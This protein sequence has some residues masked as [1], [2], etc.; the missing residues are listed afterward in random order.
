M[1]TIETIQY[2]ILVPER[3][4]SMFDE[5]LFIELTA[6]AGFEWPDGSAL[7]IATTEGNYTAIFY[8]NVARVYFDNLFFDDFNS[9]SKSISIFEIFNYSFSLIPK[10]SIGDI[11]ITGYP[12]LPL[13]TKNN[14]LSFPYEIALFLKDGNGN[15]D[16]R[17]LPAITKNYIS[18]VT[19]YRLRNMTGY[20]TQF[21][22]EYATSSVYFTAPREVKKEHV[23]FEWVDDDGNWRSWY[24]MLKETKTESAKA[25][26]DVVKT[27]SARNN[28]RMVSVDIKRNTVSEVYFSGYEQ[29]DVL[30]VLNSI[31]SSSY[32]F[33]GDNKE[34]VNVVSETTTNIDIAKEF[35]FTVK[36]VTK[37]AR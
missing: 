16:P 24:F 31:K 36:S 13:W 21:S 18:D 17:I 19:G 22:D 12:L 28:E 11:K 35:Y 7:S 23:Y 20:S 33:R 8:N 14:L 34:R 26:S 15:P 4:S 1:Q 10:K 2:T 3:V 29:K 27:I 37:A 25:Y 30:E 5:E 6:K 32:V 9:A